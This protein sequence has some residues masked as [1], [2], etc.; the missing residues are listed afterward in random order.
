MISPMRFDTWDDPGRWGLRPIEGRPSEPRHDR[1][2]AEAESRPPQRRTRNETTGEW[3]RIISVLSSQFGSLIN[4]V[5][6]HSFF[7]PPS[8]DRHVVPV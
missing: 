6:I 5:S 1:L 8:L 4:Y 7:A 2:E 3:W